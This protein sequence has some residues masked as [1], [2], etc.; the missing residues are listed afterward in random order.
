MFRASHRQ[1]VSFSLKAVSD[2]A[3]GQVREVGSCKEN[4]EES[5]IIKALAGSSPKLDKIQGEAGD[6]RPID[7][8]DLQGHDV[9][10]RAT[11]AWRA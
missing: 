6:G 2:G 4:V 9:Q 1:N 10:P 8:V 7:G 3:V 11:P 5:S